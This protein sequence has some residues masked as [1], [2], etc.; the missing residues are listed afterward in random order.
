MTR[1]RLPT[2][3]V[4]P[5]VEVED[6]L[7]GPVAGLMAV[8]VVAPG[9]PPPP[10]SALHTVAERV[11]AVVDGPDP[12]LAAALRADGARVL[13]FPAPRGEG[14]ALR[15]GLR[16]A[17]ELGG[18]GALVG[19]AELGPADLARLALAHR[20]A[21]EVLLLGVGSGEAIAG[22]EWAEARALAEGLE[23]PPANDWTPPLP[24]PPLRPAL[25]AFEALVQTRFA[26]PWG[27]PRLL[28]L[29]AVLRRPTSEPG[30]GLH[31]ELLARCVVAG[32]PTHELVLDDPG[33]R[34]VLT[35]RR[36]GARLALRLG[37]A[38]AA[39]R[40]REALGLG[41]GYAPPMTSPLLLALGTALLL[42][43][44]P[45][46]PPEV[47]STCE[48]AIPLAQ[49]PGGGDPAAAWAELLAAR[50]ATGSVL[51]DQAVEVS[52][53]GLA[54][55][56]KLRGVLARDGAR[57]RVRMQAMG[58]TVLD[59]LETA[60]RWQLTVPPAGI[61]RDGLAGEPVLDA[62]S[63]PAGA[64]PMIAPE[65]FGRLLRVEGGTPRWQPGACAVLELVDAAPV[66]RYAFRPAGDA[67]EIAEETLL[68]GGAPR[69]VA[70]YDDYRP[71]GATA[72]PYRTEVRDLQ[73]GTRV[74][75]LTRDLRVGGATD[76]HF[77]FVER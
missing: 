43:G 42:V 67:W 3:P 31:I 30:A 62:A 50:A 37:T 77:A 53:P 15:A 74:V 18:I 57:V 2:T 23:P 51:V 7:D 26:R 10:L 11:V 16:L 8:L 49:W 71:A 28:P 29:Q 20:K 27:G 58:F 52:D 63:L 1:V 56:R 64:G 38:A 14:L 48:D 36:A 21:P 47:A 70:A 68:E 76:A 19:A 35:C 32:V 34:A 13:V 54:E 75:L 5:R 72:W 22:Q 73:R 60:E 66:R 9:T 25:R 40:A 24:P 39:R 46:A 4:P 59:Y 61:A 55:D 44:C 17:R 45:K 12:P 41:G 69:L 65:L 33:P 6:R